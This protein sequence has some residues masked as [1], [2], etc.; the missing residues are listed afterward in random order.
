MSTNTDILLKLA[1]NYK[2]I[3]NPLASHFVIKAI[4]P[5]FFFVTLGSLLSVY[6]LNFKRNSDI[7]LYMV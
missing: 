3:S 5:L 2:L 7:V 6:F 4:L 1:F